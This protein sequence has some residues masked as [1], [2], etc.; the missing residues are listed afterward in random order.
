MNNSN[1]NSVGEPRQGSGRASGDP[2]D[3][4]RRAWRAVMQATGTVKAAFDDDFR[5][6]TDIDIRVYDVLLHVFEAGDEGIKMTDLAREITLSKAGLTSLVDRIEKRSLVQRV[7]DPDD[8]RALRVKLTKQGEKVFRSAA[9][10]HVVG[11]RERV[12]Q[13]LTEKEARIIADAFERVRSA[14][15]PTR[16]DDRGIS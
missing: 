6:Q 7:P 14:N 5:A 11:I 1:A 12:S 3:A 9:R 4:G 13:H 16:K 2:T 8:R 15:L 10:I